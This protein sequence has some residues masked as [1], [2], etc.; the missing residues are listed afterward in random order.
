[1]SL[2]EQRC[3]SRPLSLLETGT[4]SN[5]KLFFYFLLQVLQN[6]LETETEYSKDLQSLLTN[7]LRPLQ[8]ID[9]YD[10]FT[11]KAWWN[12]NQ[13]NLAWLLYNRNPDQILYTSQTT[14]NF[15][16]FCISLNMLSPFYFTRPIFSSRLSSSDVALILGNLEE[17]STFQQMLVQSLEECTKLVTPL[18]PAHTAPLQQHLHCFIISRVTSSV[19]LTVL[20]GCSKP[21]IKP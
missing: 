4:L 17:I 7:Y 6:I 8:S 10:S 13:V 19:G 5:L 2:K 18:L 3:F 21:G 9:K 20:Q 11:C 16:F 1:M 15:L 12:Q 14:N